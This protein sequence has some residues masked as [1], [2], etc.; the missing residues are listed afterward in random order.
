[1]KKIRDVLNFL[2]LLCL[3]SCILQPSEDHLPETLSLMIRQA[4]FGNLDTTDP[5]SPGICNATRAVA[6][7]CHQKPVCMV[8]A[9]SDLCQYDPA[10]DQPEEIE[11]YY[12]CGTGQERYTYALKNQV[13]RLDCRGI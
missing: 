6:K 2:L 1:M 12:S 11:I 5:D 4:H 7:L 3:T 13:A 9:S 10:P 8:L